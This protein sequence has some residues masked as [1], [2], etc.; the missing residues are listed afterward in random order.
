MSALVQ[1]ARSV[2]V[3]ASILSIAVCARAQC[4]SWEPGFGYSAP[5]LSAGGYA[6]ATTVFDDGSGPALYVGG[7][8]AAA[9]GVPVN[10]IARW[11]GAHWTA[12]PAASLYGEITAMTVFDDGSG[13]RL[14]V[15]TLGYYV[16]K[17]NGQTW[18]PLPGSSLINQGPV[19]ALGVFDDGSGPALYACGLFTSI[20]S[21]AANS[22]ARWNGSSWSALGSGLTGPPDAVEPFAL[23]VFDDGSG[24][25]LYVAGVFDHAG[26]VSATNIAKWDGSTW[27]PLGGGVTGALFSLTTFD[28]GSGLALYAGGGFSSAGGSPAN[29]VAKWDGASWTAL[30]VGGAGF[31]CCAQAL[32]VFDDGSGP[33]LYAGGTISGGGVNGRVARWNGASWMQ[34]GGSFSLEGNPYAAYVRNLTVLGTGQ[35][36]RLYA[37]G[38]FDQVDGRSTFSIASTDGTAWSAVPIPSGSGTD[39]SVLA[40]ATFDD[41]H[42]AAL[43]AGGNLRDAGGTPTVG[44]GRWDGTMWTSLGAGL[45]TNP[46]PTQLG[47][48]DALLAFDGPSGSPVLYVGGSFNVPGDGIAYWDGAS[49]TSMSVTIGPG[50][51][52]VARA[53]AADASSGA[54]ALYVGGSFNYAGG[55]LAANIAR[56]DPHTSQWSAL[57]GG[58]DGDVDALAMFDD[59]TGPALYAAGAFNNVGG[60]TAHRIARWNGSGWSTLGSGLDNIT[61]ALAVF[62]D[63]TGSALYAGGTFATAGGVPASHVARWNG[64]TWS[65][66]GGGLANGVVLALA[67]H[68]DGSGPALYAAGGFSSSGGIATRSISRWDGHSWTPLGNGLNGIAHALAP[69][70]DGHGGGPSLFVGGEFTSAGANPS[71]HLAAWRGCGT[72]LDTFCFGDGTLARCPCGNE[73]LPGHGCDNSHATGGA[74]MLATGTTQPDTIVLHASGELPSVLS[75]FLQGNALVPGSA[76]FGDGLRCVSGSLKRLYVKNASAGVVAAPGPGDPSITTRSAALGDPIAPGATRYYQTY[77]RDPNLAFCPSS[78]GDSWNVT[79]GVIVDW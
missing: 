43:Y 20:G 36:A 79:N 59:G 71:S 17:W 68:D 42:G 37:G 35:G 34:L 41:G 4:L 14:Y 9:G 70:N 32:A 7:S 75:I 28:D 40:L 15:A 64:S 13:P 56:F 22:I 78:Q 45:F 10:S 12:V 8:F 38:H 73:G 5:G 21:T 33:A 18:T 74:R 39:Q 25:A 26:G 31:G 65:P 2:G 53:F 50:Y 77:Y 51:T 29:G 16:W 52:G 24:P 61:V 62:D 23:C 76:S 3:V 27:S 49:W 1:L 63:G 6:F 44:I 11:D 60:V 54:H 47:S 69:F 66:V 57:S 46:S 55:I 30:G 58:A 67:V 48:A 72:P 19:H